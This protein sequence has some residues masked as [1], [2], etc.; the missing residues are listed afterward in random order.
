MSDLQAAREALA[1]LFE[2]GLTPEG[3]TLWARVPEVAALVPR[4]GEETHARV[5]LLECPAN[6]GIYLRADG[7]GEGPGLAEDLRSRTGLSRWLPAWAAAVE[8]VDDGLYAHAARLAVAVMDR[9][10]VAELPPVAEPEDL[11]ALA[12]HLALPAA[13]GGWIPNAEI[14]GLGRALDLPTGFGR[15]VD[16]LETLLGSAVH[17]G[18]LPA[19]VGAL[20]G[21]LDRWERAWEPFVEGEPWRVRIATTRRVLREVGG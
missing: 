8:A 3:R 17:Y 7:L 5:M 15:R 13:A 2:R 9:G 14:V 16:R 1:E 4:I 18:Q 10:E 21:V 20:V 19:L 12:R 6:A 11:G